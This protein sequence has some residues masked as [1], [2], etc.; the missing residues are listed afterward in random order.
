MFQ[1]CCVQNQSLEPKNLQFVGQ[2]P[3]KQLH[4]HIVSKNAPDDARKAIKLSNAIGGPVLFREDLRPITQVG[5]YPSNSNSSIAVIENQMKKC[6]CW[7]RRR[8]LSSLEKCSKMPSIAAKEQG[9]WLPWKF[10]L[11]SRH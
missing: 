5:T 1:F 4:S 10:S 6:R 8:P 2:K 9:K 11:P 3:A 7:R